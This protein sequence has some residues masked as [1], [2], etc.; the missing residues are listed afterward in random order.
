MGLEHPPI[1]EPT[2]L[3]FTD[4][5]GRLFSRNM[6]FNT[7]AKVQKD[8]KLVTRMVPISMETYIPD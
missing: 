5:K 1:L 6:E 7:V 4:S 8:S 3:I 2:E